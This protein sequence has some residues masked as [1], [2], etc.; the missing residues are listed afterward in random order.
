MSKIAAA[1][2][3]VVVI[4]ANTADA[5]KRM[6]VEELMKPYDAKS[7]SAPSP[8]ASEEAPRTRVEPAPLLAR[9]AAAPC[10]PLSRSH[11]NAGRCSY[12]EL[13]AS[14]LK[15]RTPSGGIRV[16]A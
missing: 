7:Q 6:T 16:P 11:A 14:W 9:L 8:A 2:A 15:H 4:F 10:C 13:Y 12:S 1:G 5:Q 3:A